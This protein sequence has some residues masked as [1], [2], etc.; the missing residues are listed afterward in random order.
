MTRKIQILRRKIHC[1]E[2]NLRYTGGITQK[3][4]T[5]GG[6]RFCGSLSA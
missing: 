4:V 5:G 3:R 6:A 1:F 2:L